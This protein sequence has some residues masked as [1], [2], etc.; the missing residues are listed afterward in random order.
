MYSAYLPK[1]SLSSVARSIFVF[2]SICITFHSTR[3]AAPPVNSG[4][5]TTPKPARPALRSRKLFDRN[6]G[7]TV[8]MVM[9]GEQL[10]EI[11]KALPASV[12]TS[13]PEVGRNALAGL[14][15]ALKRQETTH[16]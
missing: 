13:T 14:R 9:A 3:T 5:A 1:S 4:A 7:V 2:I 16:A 6:Y 10:R 15:A 8:D 11:P 12:S